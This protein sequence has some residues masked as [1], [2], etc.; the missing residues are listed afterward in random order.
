[1]TSDEV[2]TREEVL[3]G[4][5]A[6]LNPSTED[7][8]AVIATRGDFVEPLD[9]LLLAGDNSYSFAELGL[10][11]LCSVKDFRKYVDSFQYTNKKGKVT[12][13]FSRESIESFILDN[14]AIDALIPI[15]NTEKYMLKR[16][17]KVSKENSPFNTFKYHGNIAVCFDYAFD[18][19]IM[20]DIDT[21]D[22]Y[23]S[24]DMWVR[25]HGGIV[26]IDDD[27]YNTRRI[28]GYLYSPCEL[29]PSEPET[30]EEC[31]A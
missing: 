16:N 31:N 18:N 19:F 10:T 6:V 20:R 29:K 5:L 3:A 2:M 30:V 14:L 7:M 4:Y 9:R 8:S 27:E 25:L 1:M 12:E 11:H 26:R 13:R 21:N 23:I 22:H 28:V 15:A 17:K 24:E